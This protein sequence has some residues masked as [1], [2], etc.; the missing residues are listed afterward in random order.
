MP[1][2]AVDFAVVGGGNTQEYFT[3][4]QLESANKL[5]INVPLFGLPQDLEGLQA[6]HIRVD[7]E[8]IYLDFV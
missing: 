8:V 4:E 6:N 1:E 7:G 2:M 3:S 5:N